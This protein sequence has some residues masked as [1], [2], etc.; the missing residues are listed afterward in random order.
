MWVTVSW[1]ALAGA[2]SVTWAPPMPWVPQ[3][4]MGYPNLITDAL[5]S[6]QGVGPGHVGV[7]AQCEPTEE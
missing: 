5:G 2:E 7:G 6:R 4:V 3:R 1:L